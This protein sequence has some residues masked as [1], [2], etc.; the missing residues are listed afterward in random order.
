MIQVKDKEQKLKEWFGKHPKVVVALSG[1]VD[2]CLVAFAARKF[3]GKENLIAVISDS[4]SLKA[5]DLKDAGKFCSDYDI[6]LEIVDA[7][8]IDDPNY[9]SNPKDR[10]FFCKSALYTELQK[11]IENK[12]PKHVMLNGNNYSDL[13]DYRPGLKA[14]SEFHAYSPLAECGFNKDDIR[15]LSQHFNLFVW[16]KPASPCLSSRFPYGESITVE[17]LRMVEDAEEVLYDY[18]FHMARVRHLGETAR[19]E[20]PADQL[21]TLEYIF[22][23][24]RAKIL[25]IGFKFCEIDREGFISGKLNRVLKHEQ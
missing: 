17:K 22:E 11:L 1:G 24:V 3:L 21:D 10:C 6:N 4:A 25:A 16:D 13:G 19:I 5:R 12:Y 18:G 2:S 23:E 15:E 20:V 7:R 14:A 9:A 8:E